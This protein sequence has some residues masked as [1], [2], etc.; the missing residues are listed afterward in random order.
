MSDSRVASVLERQ[1]WLD[2]TAGSVQKGVARLIESGGDTGQAAANLL[3]GTWL[4]HPVHAAV[5]DIPVGAW[6]AAVVMDAIADVSGREEAS[7]ASDAAIAI[8]LA[9][10]VVAAAAG[11]TD[12]HATDG[13]ARQVGFVHGALN[14]TGAALFAAS[15]TARK[16]G[17]RSAGRGLST[18]GYLVALGSAWLGGKL[19]YEEQVGVDHT[20]GQRFPEDFTAVLPDSELPEGEM[21]RAEWNGNRILLARRDG[22][23]YA[24]A[25]VC[26]HFGGPLAEGEFEGCAVRCP[27]HGSRFSLVDGSVIDGPSVHRQPCLETR[28]AG[29]QIEVRKK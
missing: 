12:W 27:W 14:I 18:L 29:E 20:V 4:G 15:L 21:R 2:R 17:A 16:R 5:T 11:I 13:R 8:G 10:A 24:I 25:E 23:I 1:D 6:T 28:V 19:V 9:G 7:R 3:H 22:Q 26:S